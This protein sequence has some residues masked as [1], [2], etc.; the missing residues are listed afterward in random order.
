MNPTRIRG[1]M[2]AMTGMCRAITL[3]ALAGAVGC[4]SSD[5]P[6]ALG[7][8]AT[9]SIGGA[10]G[11]NVAANIPPINLVLGYVGLEVGALS[12]EHQPSVDVKRWQ[13]VIDF[14][15][16]PT[17][18]QTFTIVSS[19]GAAGGAAMA[20]M[21]IEELPASGA[22]REWSAVSG[23]I[24]VPTRVGDQ[25]T[26]AFEGVPFQP[27]PGGSGNAATGMF[28]LTGRITVDDIN[29]PLPKD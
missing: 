4:G 18:G 21:E 10:A 11:S 5:G 23:S 2:G 16:T 7:G 17:S 13:L 6:P 22:P 15:S 20:A 25:A 19:R 3:V 8:V 28:T 27:A 24:A 9:L 26:V 1:T 12:L 14:G 29:Q